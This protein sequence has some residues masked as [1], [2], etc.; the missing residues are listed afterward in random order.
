MQNVPWIFQHQREKLAECKTELQK[1]VNT[2]V[3]TR[4][5][6]LTATEK[7][8]AMLDP[9]NI[10]KRGFTITLNKHGKAVK[11][12]S[13]IQAGE[14]ITTVLADGQVASRVESTKKSD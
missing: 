8:V 1:Q 10:L 13:E 3:S 12:F 6:A 9:I 11:H 7:N 4:R 2:L 5:E 14:S